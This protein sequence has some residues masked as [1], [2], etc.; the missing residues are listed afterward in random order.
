MADSGGNQRI[1]LTAPPPAPIVSRPLKTG[2]EFTLVLPQPRFMLKA[3]DK[4]LYDPGEEANLLLKGKHLGDGPYTLIVER[5]DGGSWAEVDRVQ[6]K[7]DGGTDAK[8]T[9]KFP[10][11]KKLAGGRFTKAEWLQA[12]CKPGEVL[13]MAIEAE[14]LEGEWLLVVVE[15]EE[16]PGQWVPETRWDG[17]LK[18]GKFDTSWKTPE[19]EREAPPQTGGTISLLKWADPEHKVGEL[20]WLLVKAEKMDEESLKF[21]LER[22]IGPGQWETVGHATSTIKGGEARAGIAIPKRAQAEPV[23]TV[24][25]ARFEGKVQPGEEVTAAVTTLNMDGQK[26]SLLLDVEIGGKW[27]EVDASEATVAGDKASGKLKL[28]ALELV[29]TPDLPHEELVSAKFTGKLEIGEP[30]SLDVITKGMDGQTLTLILE[31]A[32]GG[33]WVPVQETTAHVKG[34]AASAQMVVPAPMRLLA[35]S[36]A[37][38]FEKNQYREGEDITL[39]LDSVG[40]DGELVDLSIEEE[41]PDGSFREVASDRALLKTGPVKLKLVPPPRQGTV[42]T[43]P[44]APPGAASGSSG[45]TSRSQQ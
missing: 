30:V 1:D 35:Q 43:G 44:P 24:Q 5:E 11:V 3:W 45:G 36:V 37:A 34:D 22:E 27:V 25:T 4:A 19:L 39:V 40:L 6:A 9:Y 20:A 8:A 28:P 12:E 23:A 32:E 21:E 7:V 26:I 33:E 17:H 2:K 42:G 18:D 31:V 15:R 14:G 13:Q 16:A 29:A 41:Q 10:A 38:G